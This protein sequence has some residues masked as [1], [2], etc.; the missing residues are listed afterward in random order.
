VTLARH[1]LQALWWWFHQTKTCRSIIVYFNENIN[2]LNIFNCAL[3]WTNK[4]IGYFCSNLYFV[5]LL[6][7]YAQRLILETVVLTFVYLYCI[8]R[9]FCLCVMCFFWQVSCPTVVWQNLWT[10]EMIC[11]YVYMHSYSSSFNFLNLSYRN[12]PT[13]CVLKH[14]ES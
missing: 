8:V 5:L 11:M 4:R 3:C 7:C 9:L 14:K 2:I 6:L 1:R 12:S 10:Y 13:N